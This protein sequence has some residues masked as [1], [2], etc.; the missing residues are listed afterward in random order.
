MG[1][2]WQRGLSVWGSQWF[3]GTHQDRGCLC[4]ISLP[5]VFL[6]VFVLPLK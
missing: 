6:V 1:N 3:V 2:P 4:G 5:I